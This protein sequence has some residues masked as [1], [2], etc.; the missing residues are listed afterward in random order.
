MKNLF[1]LLLLF[2]TSCE[3]NTPLEIHNSNSDITAKLDRRIPKLVSR[4][5]VDGISVSVL[6]RDQS[7]VFWSRGKEISEHTVFE[8]ASLGKPVFAYLV[9]HCHQKGVIDLDAPIRKY[10]DSFSSNPGTTAR[11]LLQHSSGLNNFG[12]Q[13]D[14]DL[15]TQPG[16]KFRYSGKGYEL[17][18]HILEE[19]TG[20][21][22]D[23]MIQETV[24]GPLEMTSSGFTWK[25]S[26]EPQFAKG[27]NTFGETIKNQKSYLQPNAAFS[28]Y[29]T[30]SDYQKFVRKFID[31]PDKIALSM[32]QPGI[33]INRETGWGPGWASRKPN[34]TI[35]FGIGA[36]TPV[37]E[38]TSSAIRLKDA[39]SWCYLTVKIPS[40]SSSP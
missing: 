32:T 16:L 25:K 23:E 2:C 34:R 33:D 38:I 6:R 12:D 19:L 31:H 13:N 35:R 21:S 1:A 36:V 3:K 24:T 9:M 39:Q 28:F 14:S 40:K 11:H 8:A 5:K 37:I 17:L 10:T 7:P 15:D 18:Q 4:H 29:T 26:F 30:A 22:L 27:H 20:K